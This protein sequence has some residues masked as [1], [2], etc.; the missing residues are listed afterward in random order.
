MTQVIIDYYE[1]QEFMEWK[2]QKAEVERQTK[3]DRLVEIINEY[4]TECDGVHINPFRIHITEY[5]FDEKAQLKELLNGCGYKSRAEA[6]KSQM[7]FTED[8]V[9]IV[10][11]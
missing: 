5:T 1:Y 3:I 2:K 9:L 10:T 6:I 8:M 7:D 4:F 11:K